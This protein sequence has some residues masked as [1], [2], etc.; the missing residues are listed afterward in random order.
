MTEDFEG[1]KRFVSVPKKS[2]ELLAKRDELKALQEVQR[3]EDL[4]KQREVLESIKRRQQMRELNRALSKQ[5]EE[6]RENTRIEREIDQAYAR[7]INFRL[8]KIREIDRNRQ[9]NIHQSRDSYKSAL[10]LQISERS[11]SRQDLAR[12]GRDE[13]QVLRRFQPE[14]PFYRQRKAGTHSFRS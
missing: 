12:L 5:L 13:Q 3:K 7:Q 14:Q 8:A 6:K 1:V 4:M 11:K 10:L 9:Q 2:Q